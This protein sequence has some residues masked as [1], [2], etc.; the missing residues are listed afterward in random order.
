MKF[1]VAIKINKILKF[2]NVQ[3]NKIITHLQHWRIQGGP[4]GAMAPP[5]RKKNFF[6]YTT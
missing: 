2:F 1:K 5:K 3:N 4:Q 6:F